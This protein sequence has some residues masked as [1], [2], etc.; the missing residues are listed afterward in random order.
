MAFCCSFVKTL[1]FK[2]LC[3]SKSSFSEIYALF[4]PVASLGSDT[5]PTPSINYGNLTRLQNSSVAA[6]VLLRIESRG[7]LANLCRPQLWIQSTFRLLQAS[8]EKL[9]PLKRKKSGSFNTPW[10][11]LSPGRATPPQLGGGGNLGGGGQPTPLPAPRAPRREAI[12]PLPTAS[13]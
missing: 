4:F 9:R 7:S 1:L 8:R 2:V 10:V 6:G 13:T 11:L 5:T 3:D 12:S